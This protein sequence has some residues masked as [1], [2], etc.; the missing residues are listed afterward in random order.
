[1]VPFTF[2]A[3]A[4]H[5]IADEDSDPGT[6]DS[7]SATMDSTGTGDDSGDTDT[8][9]GTDSGD[10]GTP[11]EKT[12][13]YRDAD[14]DGFGDPA[15]SQL[16]C[17][18][19]AGFVADA[20]DCDDLHPGSYPGA[21]EQPTDGL[22]NDC[23]GVSSLTSVADL[24]AWQA[25]GLYRDSELGG[26]IASD[27]DLNG[28]GDPDLILG[29][30]VGEF[31]GEPRGA[32]VLVFSGPL[33]PTTAPADE[34]TASVNLYGSQWDGPSA[35]CSVG[36]L[37]GDTADD[38]VIGAS[39]DV[40]GTGV[41]YVVR[42][43][44]EGAID[45][46]LDTQT[47]V[48]PL[49]GAGLRRCAGPG[50]VDGDGISDLVLAAP[51]TGSDAQGS[52]YLLPG[53]VDVDSLDDAAQ[54]LVGT[55]DEE[56]L[57]VLINA[58]GDLDGDGAGDFGISNHDYRHVLA[59]G[60]AV[61]LITDHGTGTTH[62]RDSGITV[63]YDLSSSTAYAQP[64]RVGDVN[65]DGY[66]DVAFGSD[67]QGFSRVMSLVEGPLGTEADLQLSEE[68]AITFES[69]VGGIELWMSFATS[70]GD[71]NGDGQGALA[72]GAPYFAPHDLMKAYD[73]DGEDAGLCTNGAIF[74]MAEPVEPGVY[75]LA[76]AAD[77][78]EGSYQSGHM[79][80]ALAGGSD[81]D[82][83]GTPDL[84][85]GAPYADAP[86]DDEGA[87]YVLFGGGLP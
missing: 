15:T 8:S 49:R 28:D 22:V 66:E 42:G 20:T 56:R 41:A 3:L 79:G 34:A 43:P 18:A 59:D 10:S 53:P 69:S 84:A 31:E 39:Y 64:S 54:T 76:T 25:V 81:L 45:L 74:I 48:G 38:L 12:I 55:E 57:G 73:C 35:V 68:A 67:P 23:G 72:V 85:F 71:W 50:D 75:D 6:T 47:F 86:T 80:L 24:P 58:L 32:S 40:D 19:P 29:G 27:A 63:H 26:T 1:M 5:A 46:T 33:A 30:Y 2:L 82:G 21:P 51:Y 44:L 36:D 61:Y 78:V 60:V 13:W 62:P 65:G 4:C 52:V 7:H 70:L 37:D 87:A 11:C 14:G 16:A 9:P 83:D 17:V 77:R